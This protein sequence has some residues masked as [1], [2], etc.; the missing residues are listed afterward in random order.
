MPPARWAKVKV[1]ERA[2]QRLEGI[3]RGA[4]DASEQ[5]VHGGDGEEHAVNDQCERRDH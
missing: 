1:T 4:N 3:R 5:V 2:Q